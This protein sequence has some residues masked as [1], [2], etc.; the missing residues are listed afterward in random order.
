MRDKRTRGTPA[1]LVLLALLLMTAVC[2]ERLVGTKI[3]K[4]AAD[5]SSYQ[6]Q[7]VTVA[8]TVTERIDVPSVRCYVVSDG[9]SSIGV[10][11]KGNLP[12]PGAKV[13]AK[14]RVEQSFA[15]GAR[16]L[17]V[18][19]ETPKSRP[20]PPRNPVVPGGGPT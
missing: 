16:K 14:G 9:K 1:G 7:V 5:P 17:L 13:R 6:G 2:C 12:V 19:I 4:I 15:I 3:A 11:T 18:I 10:V 20:T 8:G